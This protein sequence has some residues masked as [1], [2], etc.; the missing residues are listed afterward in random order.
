MANASST[1][2]EVASSLVRP[3]VLVPSPMGSA[4]SMSM[5]TARP[6]DSQPAS[7]SGRC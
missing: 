3:N 7:T 2:R 6:T 1:S 5:I 4:R